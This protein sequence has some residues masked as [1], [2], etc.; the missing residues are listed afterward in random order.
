MN[1]NRIPLPV[2]VVIL[3]WNGIE[4]TTACMDSLY[5]TTDLSSVDVVVVDN[6]SSDGTVNYLKSLPWITPLFNAKNL[7]FV[8]GN[9]TALQ[10]IDKNRDIVLLNNDTEIHD[11]QWIQKLQ[12]SAYRDESI[13]IVG[14]RIRRINSN[15]LQHAGTFMPDFTYWGQQV[16]GGEKDINQYNQDH[17]VEGIVFACAFIK[18]AVIEKIGFLDED[19]F[20]YYE[21]TD[22]CFKA[23]VAGFRIINCGALTILHREHGSTACNKINHTEMFLKSQKI[24]LRKWKRFLD[25][26]HDGSIVWHSTFSRP[27]GYAMSSRLIATALEEVGI[28]VA[29]QYLYGPGTVFPVEEERYVNS[30]NYRIEVIKKR[31][32][33]K[34]A[35]HLVYG[36]ADAF[37]QAVQGYRIGFTMLE[38]TGIPVEWVHQCNLLDEV[39]VPSPFNAWTFR[40][41]GVTRPI[42]IMPLGLININYFNPFITSYP[43]SGVFTFISIFEWGERKAPEILLRAFNLAFR[44]DEPVVLICKYTCSDPGIHP[45]QLIKALN[46][47]PDGG[48]IVYSENEAVPYYQIPQLY[49]SADCFVLP[50][51]GE[52]WGMP[53]LEAM[54]CGLPVIASF[55]SAQQYFMNDTN[56]Y[57]LQVSLIEARAKCPYY[58]GFK[59]ANP[60]E[61]H[62]VQLLRNVYEHPDEARKKGIRAARDVAEKWSLPVTAKRMRDRLQEVEAERTRG[63]SPCFS[64]GKP[65][66]G[67]RSR[68]GID[69]SRAVGAEVSGIG[70]YT[71]GLIKGL[72]R[73][74]IDDNPFDYALLPG[75]GAYVHPEY[76]RPLTFEFEA[77]ERMT[78][79]RGPLPAFC[80]MDHYVPGLDIVHCTANN[81]PDPVDSPTVFVV[82]DISF[83]THRKFHTDE[84]IRWCEENFQRALRSGSFFVSVSE[85]TK[86]DMVGY[87]GID[88]S[89]VAVTYNGIDPLEYYPHQV[90]DVADIRRKYDLPERFFLFVGS[91]EPRKNLSAAIQSMD[92]YK[93]PEP[94][95]IVGASGWLNSGLHELIRRYQSRVRVLGYVPQG[96]LPGIYSAAAV[97]VYP[98]LYEGFGLPVVE[99]MACGTPVVTSNNSALTEIAESAAVLLDE[100]TD[101]RKI[102]EALSLLTEDT[103]FYAD[104]VAKGRERSCLYTPER[105]ATATVEL[106]RQILEKH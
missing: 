91:L 72:S 75:F 2:T 11:P 38:T 87:Y 69:V 67:A 55:W 98:S 89:R 81:K 9:N 65:S 21:D 62:L 57:P 71:T 86:K 90:F 58:Q 15:M 35:V 6:G 53:I 44:K 1:D 54:A 82:H 77:D 20:S 10:F 76:M 47:D 106:Y 101:P 19:Y 104:M 16:G 24:F 52:G 48:N 12:E 85:S 96:D 97:T 92:F 27:M 8:R 102:A 42:Q 29:Y 39:W 14:S 84:N 7:G 5:H 25:K 23:K 66:S 3:T 31:K 68:I 50:T 94:L 30:G 22:Y 43:I 100:P 33:R 79:Y 32:P 51:R 103:A 70:R 18:R 63:Q 59:W 49:R 45:Q 34:G 40:R 26:R 88:P 46:L 80:D 78:L 4:Y 61:D 37:S 36:Q 73:L 64:I 28:E 13:G 93:G 41:S 60:D 95:V 17:E 99:S 74:S 105:C 83:A 56:S